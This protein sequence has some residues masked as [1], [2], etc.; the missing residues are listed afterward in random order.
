[1]NESLL[2][3]ANVSTL[4]QKL[5]TQG[6]V[7]D[8]LMIESK[9]KPQGSLDQCDYII[10][11]LCVVVFVLCLSFFIL[12]LS[13]YRMWKKKIEPFDRQY[14][15]AMKYV[16][17]GFVFMIATQPPKNEPLTPIS[18]QNVGEQIDEHPLSHKDSS[19]SRQ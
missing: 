2:Y 1:M 4:I 13:T 7:I 3:H 6:N 19:E 12:F 8:S 14:F 11:F 18:A 9:D 17:L 10:A 16:F 5:I 15:S